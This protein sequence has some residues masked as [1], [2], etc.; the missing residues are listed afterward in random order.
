MWGL[1]YINASQKAQGHTMTDISVTPVGRV[2]LR[3]GKNQG[4]GKTIIQ[5][6]KKTRWSQWNIK[7]GVNSSSFFAVL[8]TA[9]KSKYWPIIVKPLCVLSIILFMHV[10]I[11]NFVL[12]CKDTWITDQFDQSITFFTLPCPCWNFMDRITP[13]PHHQ[14]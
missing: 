4:K 14:N 5:V 3:N 13:L 10:N 12:L 1:G 9:G 6:L 11:I 7:Q 2:G 8:K